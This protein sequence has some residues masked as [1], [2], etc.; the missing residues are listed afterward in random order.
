MNSAKNHATDVLDTHRGSSKLGLMQHIRMAALGIMLGIGVA[1]C[2]PASAKALSDAELRGFLD[3]YGLILPGV[4]RD[5]TWIAVGYADKKEDAITIAR[6]EILR[7]GYSEDETVS[8]IIESPAESGTDKWVTM[9]R[10]VRED[11]SETDEEDEG[12]TSTPQP[13]QPVLNAKLKPGET[14]M[15]E[16]GVR[17]LDSS[18]KLTVNRGKIHYRILGKTRKSGEHDLFELSENADVEESFI[19]AGYN[20]N[21]EEWEECG[22]KESNGGV[23]G[24]RTPLDRMYKNSAGISDVSMVHFHPVKTTDEQDKRF[25]ISQTPSFTDITSWAAPAI[26]S[27]YMYKPKML[28]KMDFRIVTTSGIYVIKFPPEAV[29]NVRYFIPMVTKQANRLN[30]ERV[31]D[32]PHF[33]Y[34]YK[35]KRNFV[36]ENTRF[37]KRFSSKWMKITF[38]PR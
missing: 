35:N 30:D 10:G 1:G 23:I 29:Q 12:E 17:E 16:D 5:G 3:K 33:N 9:F 27:I 15:A 32:F 7:M 34:R 8:P 24:D 28:D 14:R 31:D 36:R 22:I 37:A 11:K 2:M 26:M 6:S 38:I 19:Y 21:E 13:Q 4:Q 18:Q 25:D 20:D